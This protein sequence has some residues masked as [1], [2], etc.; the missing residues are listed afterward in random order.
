MKDIEQYLRENRPEPPVEGQFLIETNARLSKVEGIRRSIE[1]ERR[2]G[3][4]ALIAALAA[5]LVVGC[6]A[7]L[8]VL[9]CPVPSI[10]LERSAVIKAAAAL[11]E[12]WFLPAG[13]IAVCALSLG[14]V[15]VTR[16]REVL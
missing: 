11:R 8:F 3:R 2:R 5:G 14:I 12:W 1:E 13:L 4:V 7:T 15:F 6:L 16:K 9:F 10:E